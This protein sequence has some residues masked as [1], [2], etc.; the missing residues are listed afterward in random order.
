MITLLGGEN[1][2][3]NFIRAIIPA[4]IFSFIEDEVDSVLITIVHFY[5]NAFP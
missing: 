4:I 1:G 5:N 2:D 3:Y